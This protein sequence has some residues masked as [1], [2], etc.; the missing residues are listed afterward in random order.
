LGIAQ[1][2]YD[3]GILSILQMQKPNKS[4]QLG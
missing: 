3:K 4:V 2:L 1:T